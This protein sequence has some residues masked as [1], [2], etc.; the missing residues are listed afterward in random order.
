MMDVDKL[1]RLVEK[2]NDLL[3]LMPRSKLFYKNINVKDADK[4]RNLKKLLHTISKISM[5]SKRTNLQFNINDFVPFI[6]GL[7][8]CKFFYYN[9]YLLFTWNI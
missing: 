5:N 7:D 3:K 4:I 1:I 6:D 8:I 9:L 2:N